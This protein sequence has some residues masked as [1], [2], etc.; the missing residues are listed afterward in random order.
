MFEN[1]KEIELL[2]PEIIEKYGS[3]I[4]YI[5]WECENPDCHRT[6]GC[7]VTDNTLRADQ[8]VCQR[9]ASLTVAQ[10]K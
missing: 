1:I 3:H 4:K 7:N 6:W 10:K 8:M 5:L 9:C 2:N